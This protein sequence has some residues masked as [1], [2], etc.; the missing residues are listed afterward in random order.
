MKSL[1]AISIVIAS[2]PAYSAPASAYW[3]QVLVC[4]KKSVS[5]ITIA[6]VT[7]N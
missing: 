2:I 6:R 3:T 7:D 5:A 4:L 1:K